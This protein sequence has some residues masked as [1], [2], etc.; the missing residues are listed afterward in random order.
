MKFS[1]VWIDERGV[2][3]F[4]TDRDEADQA[5]HKGFFIQLIPQTNDERMA[6]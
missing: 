1:Y 2:K 4:T 5:L 6:G 3:H